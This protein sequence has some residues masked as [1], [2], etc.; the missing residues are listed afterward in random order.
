MK[1]P[2]KKIY[3]VITLLL[4]G[5]IGGYQSNREVAFAEDHVLTVASDKNDQLD[6]TTS[7]TVKSEQSQQSLTS[8]EKETPATTSTK[9]PTITEKE[10]Q[11]TA[12]ERVSQS[13]TT[14]STYSE[15]KAALLNADIQQISIEKDIKIQ[16]SFNF[17][18]SKKIIGNGHTIDVN[19]QSIG[20]ALSNAVCDIEEVHLINQPIYS[21]FWSEYPGVIVNYKNVTSSGNQ[22]IYLAAGTANLSGTIEASASLEEVFQGK[23]LNIAKDA[24]IMFE[25]T[26]SAAAIATNG[27]VTVGEKA[28]LTVHAKGLGL[29][30]SNND[31]EINLY[32]K[33][34]ITS[35]MDSAIR[36][37]ANN[38]TL[39]VQNEAE[40]SV[41]SK[42]TEEE[43]ILMYNGS[44]IVKANGT[45][46]ATS[47]GIQSTVQTGKQLALQEGANFLI[48]N[49]KGNAL[50]A[51][52]QKTAVTL[53]SPQGINT[54]NLGKS[55]LENPDTSYSGPL[56]ASFSLDTYTPEQHTLDLKSDNLTFKNTFDSGK[57]GKITGGRF[58]KKKELA[59]TTIDPLTTESTQ[60][61]GTAE[62]EAAIDIKV[63]N[64]VI[65]SGKV[66]KQG[67]YQLAVPKLKEGVKVVAVAMRW[68]LSAVASTVVQYAGP[69]V[70]LPSEISFGTQEIPAV[71]AEVK[72][73]NEQEIKVLDNSKKGW[74]ICLREELPL[75]KTA[76]ALLLNRLSIKY[77]GHTYRI[78]S[79]N[80]PVLKGEGDLQMKLA[81]CLRLSLHPIDTCGLYKGELVWTIMSGP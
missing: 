24:K 6:K 60:V 2:T 34:E 16:E 65:A 55:G 27:G 4:L 59:P 25:D 39:V 29:L 35:E 1:N 7:E 3:S 57:I 71:D 21:F 30:M 54:W 66:D 51:W 37:V 48:A 64:K 80:Q 17:V 49:S 28:N 14:V 19:F 18:G 12:E 61:S 10:D 43:A 45:L 68:N 70:I 11:Q 73:T 38:G 31:G 32:G 47:E 5:V 56:S 20:V 75:K 81:D 42:R 72:P 40:L 50:G 46:V 13:H 77:N 58:S 52:A 41:S 67:K 8:S 15:F 63:D 22:F 26:A 62:P 78:N 33:A 53:A 76:G 74:S 36:S 69:Q 44:I 9:E 23:Q 79:Q